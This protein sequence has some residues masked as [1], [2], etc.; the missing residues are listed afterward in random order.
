MGD[1][2]RTVIASSGCGAAADAL[3]CKSR[4]APSAANVHSFQREECTFGATGLL[5]KKG[6][7]KLASLRVL[8]SISCWP[9]SRSRSRLSTANGSTRPTKRESAA[10]GQALQGSALECAEPR[11]AGV[12]VVLTPRVRP[13]NGSQRFWVVRQFL[14]SHCVCR[15]PHH[16]SVKPR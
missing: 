16:H 12:V 10:A 2:L 6:K 4:T 14:P 9:T 7:L 3:A 11:S 8:G 1:V 15:P 13:Q 5:P